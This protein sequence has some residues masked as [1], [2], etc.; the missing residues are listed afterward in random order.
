M[1]QKATLRTT[2]LYALHQD[3]GARLVAFAG[4]HLPVQYPEGII[5]EHLHTR[6]AASL[7]DVS[8]MGQITVTGPAAQ[9]EL[10][11]LMPVDLDA[12]VTGQ[13]C[14]ALLTN[15]SGG[16]EDDLIVTRI[17]QDSFWLVVNGACKTNDLA[18]LERGCSQST[19]TLNEQQALLAL[20]GPRARE[21]LRASVPGIASLPFMHSLEALIDGAACRISCSGYTGEDGFEIALAAADAERVARALLADHDVA[22][23]GL[24]A[25]DS[26]RLEAG[27][28]L[29]GHELRS[30]VTPL[31]AG[32]QWAIPRSRRAAGS[33]PGGY[34]GAAILDRQLTDGVERRR[35]GLRVTGKRPVREG[36][37][38]VSS[39]GQPLGE[40][41]SGGFGPTVDAPIAMGFVSPEVSTPGTELAV[42]VR[43]T[44]L[45][46]TVA[47][48]PF[49][50]QRYYRDK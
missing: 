8:H 12:L 39:D 45:A 14:Y 27:L 18:L 11:S 3:L 29:Y 48:L 4:Y 16:V 23:A 28:C 10:E 26:L 17:T 34:P 20:Q 44:T 35:V 2:A 50:P 42:E 24:G 19:V 5:A 7:F 41:T 33:R 31:E 49:V 40:V 37:R 30:D 38:I 36:Q 25:R 15:D 1:T 46:V 13:A 43:G 47:P 32:L 6:Q 9:Q 21:I 22:M